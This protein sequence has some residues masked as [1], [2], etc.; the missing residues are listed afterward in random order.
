MV[1]SAA[2]FK[3][4]ITALVVFGSCVESTCLV[5]MESI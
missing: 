3:A 4:S 1:L 2:A 5:E